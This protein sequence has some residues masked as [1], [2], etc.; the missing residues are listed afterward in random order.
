[1]SDAQTTDSYTPRQIVDD[2]L[3]GSFAD[4]IDAT[5]V[6]VEDGV[7][8]T[9]KVVRVDRDEVLLDIGYKS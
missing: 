9:G 8:V 7:I 3:G 4:A 6:T 1:M 2:D 5:L